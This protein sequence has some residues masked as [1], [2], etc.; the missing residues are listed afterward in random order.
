VFVVFFFFF[1]FFSFF[2]LLLNRPLACSFFFHFSTVC[3]HFSTVCAHFF[4]RIC[5][6]ICL[7][8]SLKPAFGALIFL[9]FFDR[10][11]SFFFHFS[12]VCAH[13]STVCAHFFDRICL[14]ICLY[15]SLKP[16][17]GVLIFL[18]FFD[19]LRSFFD[20]LRSFFDRLRSFFRPHLPG[21]LPIFFS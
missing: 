8:F 6:M 9:S 4:D 13:F 7:Y 2:F 20:R 17:F 3:A 21:D 18:S 19:R 15:F 1:F 16:P 10:L 11:R 14:M 5:L 12:T